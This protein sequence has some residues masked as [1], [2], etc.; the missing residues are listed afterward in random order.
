MYVYVCMRRLLVDYDDTSQNESRESQMRSVRCADA[1]PSIHT[2]AI[3]DGRTD[4]HIQKLHT[5]YAKSNINLANINLV[6]FKG[7]LRA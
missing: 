5:N 1:D 2:D 6:K 4:G 3:V 7:L